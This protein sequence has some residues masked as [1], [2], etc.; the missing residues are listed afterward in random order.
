MITSIDKALAQQIVNTV[1]DVCGF[2]INF[3]NRDGI[4]FASTD[5]KRIGSFH[6]IGQ[7]AA[8]TET[9]IEVGEGQEYTGT[10]KGVNLP[11]YNHEVF[12]AVIGISGEPDEVRK[13]AYLAERITKLLIREKEL[14]AFSRTMAE[15]KHYIIQSLIDREF[16][17]IEYLMEGLKELKISKDQNKRL[18]LVRM[19]TGYEHVR[20]SS[21][22]RKIQQ[23]FEYVCITLFT[24]NYPNEYL[25][26]IEEPDFEKYACKIREFAADNR[27]ILK[28]AAGKSESIFQLAD[29]Y[30]TAQIAMQSLSDDT[31]SMAVFDELTLEIVLSALD[32]PSKEEFLRKTIS[33]L[34]EEDLALL[35]VYFEEEMSLAHTCER[36]FLHKNTVQNRLDRIWKKCGFNPRKFR[37]GVVLYLAVRMSRGGMNRL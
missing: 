18:L 26:V 7:K 29:S 12:L 27:G 17:N 35:Q 34:S 32:A 25:A 30:E 21:I 5:E 22:E 19:N 4:I 3:I 24:H 13:Y 36:L 28:I 37:E 11:V 16:S 14:N 20:L 33:K 9:V 2:H 31:D 1:K 8:K 10:Q 15:K 23:M 6:E